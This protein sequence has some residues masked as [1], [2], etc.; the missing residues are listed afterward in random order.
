MRALVARVS[1][2]SSP[3]PKEKQHRFPEPRNRIVKCVKKEKSPGNVGRVYLH[4]FPIKT[5]NYGTSLKSLAYT[6]EKKKTKKSLRAK[7]VHSY[8]LSLAPEPTNTRG[9]SAGKAFSRVFGYSRAPARSPLKPKN[10]K[11]MNDK[12]RNVQNNNQMKTKKNVATRKSCF[13]ENKIKSRE[14]GEP[15]VRKNRPIF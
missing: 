12:L 4:C 6:V 9:K 8:L 5:R 3:Q 10:Q 11:K 13:P 1:F 2:F 7:F 15:W 14:I